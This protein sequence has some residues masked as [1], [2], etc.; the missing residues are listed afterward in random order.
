MKLILKFL[1]LSSLTVWFGGVVFLSFF[2]APIMFRTFPRDHAGD[3]MAAI[4]PWFYM[5]GYIA[6]FTAFFTLI[7]LYKKRA[8]F[9]SFLILVMLLATLYGGLAAGKKADHLRQEIRHEQDSS[10]LKV[11]RDNFHIQHRLSMISNM[12]V[13]ILIPAVLLLTARN[14]SES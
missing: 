6:G 13:L 7:L 4:F 2:V 5:M 3:V 8:R 14:L 1:H 11:L 9:R 10:R 12:V